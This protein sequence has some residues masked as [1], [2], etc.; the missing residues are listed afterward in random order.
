MSDERAAAGAGGGRSLLPRPPLP[1]LGHLARPALVLDG[2]EVLARPRHAGKAQDLHRQARP[3]LLHLAALVVEHG[4]HPAPLGAG[5]HD[6]ALPQGALLH[7]HGRHRAAAAVELALDH[8]ALGGALRVGLEVEHLRLE[9][10]RLQQPVEVGLLG[11]GDLHLL[12]L[13]AE[14]LPPRSRA[15]GAPAAR[16]PGSRPACR[17]C[18]PRR[19]AGRSPR[20]RGGS[21]PPSAASRRH[22]PPP[23]APPCRSRRRRGRAWR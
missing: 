5:H 20:G 10:D 22:R 8:R 21:P 4:A 18:S 1:V 9:G 23:P 12:R 16:G 11:G 19:S 14:R 17:S 6:V 15:A 2:D 3:R 13:A 7:Q